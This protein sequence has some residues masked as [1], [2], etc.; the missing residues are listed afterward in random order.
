MAKITGGSEAV[1]DSQVWNNGGNTNDRR[2][3]RIYS[4]NWIEQGG[5]GVGNSLKDEGVA[6]VS[7]RYFRFAKVMSDDAYFAQI[8]CRLDS[9]DIGAYFAR[10]AKLFTTSIHYYM[11]Q[12]NKNEIDKGVPNPTDNPCPVCWE[13]KGFMAV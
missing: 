1:V 11:Y 13:V 2:Y 9:V 3:Y 5:S 7:E 10:T 12:I 4:D 6:S 8:T